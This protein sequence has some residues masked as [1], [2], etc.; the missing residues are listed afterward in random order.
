M[1]T[2]NQQPQD[3]QMPAP[4]S[5]IPSSNISVPAD[6]QVNVFTP[7]QEDKPQ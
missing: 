3:Q 5:E 6:S 1:N 4:P 2:E 7:V